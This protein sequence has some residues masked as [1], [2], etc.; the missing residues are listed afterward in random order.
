MVIAIKEVDFPNSQEKLSRKKQEMMIRALQK[1]ITVLKTI[2][3]PN[4]IGYIG[5]ERAPTKLSVF[6]EYIS[7]GSLH[8]LLQATDQLIPESLVAFFT[9]QIVN[10]V[11][12]LHENHII[13]GDLKCAVR[14][15]IGI[16]GCLMLMFVRPKLIVVSLEH[17][18]F[19]FRNL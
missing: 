8:S 10:G 3:H 9:R 18:S 15:S 14:L 7:G 5:F 16:L 17:F 19:R 2:S 4:I 11:A 6:L 12:Y 1:E 13:H